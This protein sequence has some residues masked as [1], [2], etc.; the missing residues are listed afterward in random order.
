MSPR[1]L[2][3]LPPAHGA[4]PEAHPDRLI[5]GHTSPVRGGA[6]GT[7]IYRLFGLS[8]ITAAAAL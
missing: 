6:P 2:P 1:C 5:V 8:W 3:G 4:G 7:H